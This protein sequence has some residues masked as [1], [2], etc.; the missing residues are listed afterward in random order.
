MKYCLI[1]IVTRSIEQR[2]ALREKVYR[3]LGVQDFK[4]RANS[5]NPKKP[6]TELNGYVI[7]APTEQNPSWQVDIAK[8]KNISHCGFVQYQYS[9]KVEM[10]KVSALKQSKNC[11]KFT[12]SILSQ[13]KVKHYKKPIFLGNV[14]VISITKMYN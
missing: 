4:I 9:Q 5:T 11:E 10:K 7:Y 8:G 2:V 14:K 1:G 6:A 12:K 13:K 3:N